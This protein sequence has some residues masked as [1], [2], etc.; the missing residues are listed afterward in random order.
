MGLDEVL[1]TFHF[2][3]VLTGAY[4]FL[5]MTD[6]TWARVPV[7]A[8]PLNRYIGKCLIS[9]HN[10]AVSQTTTLSAHH[11]QKRS[12]RG[13]RAYNR[14]PPRFPARRR[15]FSRNQ[16]RSLAAR[17]VGNLERSASRMLDPA[18][19]SRPHPHRAGSP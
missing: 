18:S 9:V 2:V 13:H 3:E 19:R 5:R 17:S 16:S 8:H 6:I 4:G 15:A 14:C 10:A 7:L 12:G 1:S 11:V